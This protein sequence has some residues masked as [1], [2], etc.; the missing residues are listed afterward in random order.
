MKKAKELFLQAYQTFKTLLGETHP[1]TITVKE[2]LDV[3]EVE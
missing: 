2:W 1:H 3:M